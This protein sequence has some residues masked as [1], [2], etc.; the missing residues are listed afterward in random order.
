MQERET[1]LAGGSL[2]YQIN[3]DEVCITGF[4]GNASEILLPDTIEGYPVRVIGK[5]AFLSKKNLKKIRLPEKTVSVQDWAFAYCDRLRCIQLP[6]SCADFGRAVFLECKELTEVSV[7]HSDEQVLP[8]GAEKLL[9]A[10]V[11]RLDAY[12]LLDLK[13]VGTEEWLAKWD[14]RL[15]TFLHTPDRTGYSRQVL[16]GEED[17]GSIDFA[18]YVSNRRMAKIRLI[19][20]RLLAPVG[21]SPDLKKEMEQYLVDHTL[22]CETD[23]TWQVLLKEYGN[24]R[25]HYSLFA[26]LGCIHS[27]NYREILHQTGEDHPE[28]KAFFIRHMDGVNNREDF[29]A[30]LEL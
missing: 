18:S 2:H 22:G 11:T 19:F 30:G 4:H 5:K 8:R 10:A 20:V 7:E 23:E 1:E 21:L 12:Y 16:C 26:E 27:G 3:N 25:E 29:F 28:M 15:L 24:S 9:A 14:A 17:Y 13:E 6:G